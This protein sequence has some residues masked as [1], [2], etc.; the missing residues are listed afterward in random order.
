MGRLG[1]C[2]AQADLSRLQLEALDDGDYL[3]AE[4]CARIKLRVAYMG[5]PLPDDISI[6]QRYIGSRTQQDRYGR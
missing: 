6:V 3:A 5:F 1:F 4:A 2:E